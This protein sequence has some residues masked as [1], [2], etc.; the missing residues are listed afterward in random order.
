MIIFSFLASSFNFGLPLAMVISS[1]L[2]IVIYNFMKD[3]IYKMNIGIIES[4]IRFFFK[5]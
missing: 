4:T 5:K 2:Y 1:L 3:V